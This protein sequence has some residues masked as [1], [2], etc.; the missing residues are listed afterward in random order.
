MSRWLH[1]G[2][3]SKAL[4]AGAN[5]PCLFPA[6]EQV[7]RENRGYVREGH[8]AA[9]LAVRN[10]YLLS[11]CAFSLPINIW[12]PTNIRDQGWSVAMARTSVSLPIS[13]AF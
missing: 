10:A 7:N 1:V 8:V 2:A 11:I 13:R 12:D 5:F 6:L 3:F 4:G 9:A